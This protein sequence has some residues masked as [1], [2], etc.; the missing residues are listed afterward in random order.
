[1]QL[2]GIPKC[3]Y[4]RKRIN[5]I[6]VWSLK[7]HGE[8]RCPRCRGISNIYLSP[9]IYVIAVVA[10]AS[11]FL[12]YFFARF[13][14][15]SLTLLTAAEVAVPFAAFFLLSLF[16]VYLEKPVIKRVKRTA[17]GRYFDEEGNELEMRHGKL[18]PT[19]R[20]ADIRD[21]SD[22][23]NDDFYQDTDFGDFDDDSDFDY[24]EVGNH[25]DYD[26]NGD[27]VYNG[28][29]DE[30][31]DE[32]S[33]YDGFESQEDLYAQATREAMFA[34]EPEDEEPQSAEYE[35]YKGRRFASDDS[36]PDYSGN[37]EYAEDYGT[38]QDYESDYASSEPQTP[39]TGEIS[40]LSGSSREKSTAEI[41]RLLEDADI[42]I[43]GEK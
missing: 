22:S 31:Y 33:D 8:Y 15:D 42:K 2:I 24:S 34:E 35:E 10:A 1:M 14:S 20:R 26:D 3:P 16:F 9:L 5:L 32:E 30:N 21:M 40:I 7:K 27:G 28:L 25:R 11:A 43:F 13:I 17:D 29:Y 36:E 39:T 18:K 38:D 12:I 37:A 4:C 41:D 6:R 19:G 23:F